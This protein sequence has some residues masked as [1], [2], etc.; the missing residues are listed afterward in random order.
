MDRKEEENHGIASTL[1]VHMMV[2]PWLTWLH[3]I[4]S[5][6]WPMAKTTMMGRAIIIAGTVDRY[7]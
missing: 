4:T 2:L 1:Y 5:I 6:I 3:T 7:R